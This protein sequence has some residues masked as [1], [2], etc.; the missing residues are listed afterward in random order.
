MKLHINQIILW[1]RNG[2]APRS[3]DFLPNKINVITG[4]KSTGKSS[5]LSII[6]YC[7]LSTDSRIV[8]EVIN[9]NVS[10]YG[11]S[12]TINSKP[13]IIVRKH[14]IKSTG[15]KEIYFDST[16]LFPVHPYINND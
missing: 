11:M 10:W 14:P 2:A 9:E 5:I 16:A 15:S 3:I 7:F 4:A 1:F 8:D 12:F 6:D 13:Y